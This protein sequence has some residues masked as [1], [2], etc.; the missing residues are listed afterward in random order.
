MPSPKL[1]LAG[2]VAAAV[3]LLAVALLLIAG[4]G[5]GDGGSTATP[6]A[7][8]TAQ[9]S[10]TASATPAGTGAASPSA[11]GGVQTTLDVPEG[12]GE[13]ALA[14]GNY[15]TARFQP[16]ASFSLGEGW[17][18][19]FDTARYVQ[20]YRGDPAGNCVC[21]VNPDGVVAQNGGGAQALP[22]GGTVDGLIDWLTGDER[23]K[24]SNPSS[25]QVGRLSGRQL[26]VESAGGTVEY[27][28]AGSQ[29]FTVKAGERQHLTVLDYRGAPLI[30]AQRSPAAEY[31]DYFTFVEQVVGGLTFSD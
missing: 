31:N 30:I 20:L 25:L 26:D 29:R 14:A 13:V 23:L 24:T 15:R 2:G 21:L 8:V 18:A 16:A 9:A 19:A 10:A 27:L 4:S 22:G 11:T 6:Q 7:S 28:S 12:G 1:L 3:V 5:D 17:S